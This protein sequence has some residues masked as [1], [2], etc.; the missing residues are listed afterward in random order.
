MLLPPSLCPA[1]HLPCT[2]ASL[3]RILSRAGDREVVLPGP[4]PLLALGGWQ[5]PLPA[6]ALPPQPWFLLLVFSWVPVRGGI[7]PVGQ[8]PLLGGALWLLHREGDTKSRVPPSVLPTGVCTWLVW[9]W[10][11]VPSCL[12]PMYVSISQSSRSPGLPFSVSTSPPV[13]FCLLPAWGCVLLHGSSSFFSLSFSVGVPYPEPPP[14]PTSLCSPEPG[15]QNEETDPARP[16]EVKPGLCLMFPSP[17]PGI[18]GPLDW[19]ESSVPHLEGSELIPH[20]RNLGNQMLLRKD[21]ALSLLLL[22]SAQG[23]R[24]KRSCPRSEPRRVVIPLP[25]RSQPRMGEGPTKCK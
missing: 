25:S 18:P 1:L 7:W 13:S 23:G 12:L 10:A 9:T 19:E 11:R 6:S 21:K 22:L 4:G 3:P 8:K 15:R 5:G 24:R 20:D 16:L 14:L 17:S 2:L